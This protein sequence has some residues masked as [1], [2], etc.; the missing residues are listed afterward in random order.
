MKI[1]SSSCNA[2]WLYAISQVFWEDTLENSTVS[3]VAGQA[4]SP[5]SVLISL[6]ARRMNSLT[7]SHSDILNSKPLFMQKTCRLLHLELL[8]TYRTAQ[9]HA[10]SKKT[11]C[12]S[13]RDFRTDLKNKTRPLIWSLHWRNSRANRKW[14]TNR[15]YKRTKN[16]FEDEK[17]VFPLEGPLPW[18]KPTHS[19]SGT[20]FS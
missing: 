15:A 19:Q 18:L 11:V 12:F 9:Q 16:I 20:G 6:N 3:H 5:W 7:A 4:G 2:Q 17:P 10:L 1:N 14:G 8:I 13:G